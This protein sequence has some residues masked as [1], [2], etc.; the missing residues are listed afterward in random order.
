MSEEVSGGG[1]G[2]LCV[3]VRIFSACEGESAKANE[4]KVCVCECVLM[5]V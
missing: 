5:S 3:A 2:A 1:G 4:L